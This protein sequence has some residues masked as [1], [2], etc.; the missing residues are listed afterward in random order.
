MAKQRSTFGKLQRT[1]DKQ[2][3]ARAKAERRAERAEQSGEPAE[4]SGPVADQQQVLAALAALHD[5]FAD[6]R[7]STDD[8]EEQREKLTS[9]LVV[10]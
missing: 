6:G 2:A 8:F 10:D 3:K 9:Q 4:P 5:S 1:A 7:I